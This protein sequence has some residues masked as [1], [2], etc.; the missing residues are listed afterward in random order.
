MGIEGKHYTVE[1]GKRVL[2]P[3]VKEQRNTDKN[4]KKTVGIGQYIY[5]FPQ[6]GDGVIDSTGNSYTMNTLDIYTSNYNKGEK[7]TLAGYNKKSFVDFFTPTKELGQSKHGQAW[8]YNVPS[9]SDMSII[10]KKADDYT[11]KTITQ[12]ILGDEADFDAAWDKIQQD[13]KAMDIEK[14]NEGISKLTAE[15]IK[16]WN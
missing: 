7:E 13:L 2:L 9:D 1:N 11:T 12:A 10:Q 4:F 3:E 16:L 15:K 8:Q 5:P 6:R 14:L